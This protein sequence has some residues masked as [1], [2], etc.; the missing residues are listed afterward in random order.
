MTDAV[1]STTS[2]PTSRLSSVEHADAVALGGFARPDQDLL[3]GGDRLP[4]FLCLD[5]SGRRTRFLD[6]LLSLGIG[7]RQHTDAL[8]LDAGQFG[9]DLLGVGQAARDLLA[10]RLEDLQDRL[11]G[12]QVQHDAHDA[13]ADDLRDEVRPVNA[14]GGSDLLELSGTLGYGLHR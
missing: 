9:L 6:Q 1:V 8:R 14:E 12:Q 13:E 3:G 11:V 4:G 2:R 7:F 10:P 5:A